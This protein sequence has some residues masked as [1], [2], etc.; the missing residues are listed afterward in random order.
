MRQATSGIESQAYTLDKYFTRPDEPPCESGRLFL[1]A[2]HPTFVN[3]IGLDSRSGGKAD[4]LL[5]LLRWSIIESNGRDSQKGDFE[6]LPR[7]F[8]SFI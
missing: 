6:M 2:H 8:L 1:L 3:G 4:G 7:S 5:G